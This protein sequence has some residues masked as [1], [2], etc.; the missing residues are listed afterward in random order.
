MPKN[1]TV[2]KK[3]DLE[4]VIKAYKKYNHE[5]DNG[6]EADN[7][8]KQWRDACVKAFPTDKRCYREFETLKSISRVLG[9]KDFETIVKVY[10]ALGYEII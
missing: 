10:Q 3:E 7:E 1:K 9:Y 6:G 8:W 2:I 5:L 4:S